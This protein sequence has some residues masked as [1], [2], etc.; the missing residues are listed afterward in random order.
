[1]NFGKSV[2]KL[3]FIS[4]NTKNSAGVGVGVGMEKEDD[5]HSEINKVD[6]LDIT[7]VVLVG[8]RC[9]HRGNQ[10]FPESIFPIPIKTALL[11]SCSL[12]LLILII[13]RTL[14]WH[15]YCACLQGVPSTL[16]T[17]SHQSSS[18]SSK[19][20]QQVILV[21]VLSLVKSPPGWR[22]FSDRGECCLVGSKEVE[23]PG[24]GLALSFAHL[25]ASVSISQMDNKCIPAHCFVDDCEYY[26]N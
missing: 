17:A 9:R 5:F 7:Y 12:I 8:L 22:N 3:S 25:S 10:L 16:G 2:I 20:W 13:M 26:Y 24:S 18:Q 4:Q 1:M 21:S 6:G 15:L 14:K 11:K 23:T 19:R